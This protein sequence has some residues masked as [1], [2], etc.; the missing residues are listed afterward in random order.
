MSNWKTLE[1]DREELVKFINASVD[2][3]SYK[4]GAKLPLHIDY[5]DLVGKEID[6]SGYARV[7]MHAISHGKIIMPDGSFNQNS[8]CRSQG[9]KRTDYD[10]ASL[11]DDRLRIAFIRPPDKNRH[12]WY[13]INGQTIESCGGYGPHRRS[14]NSSVL[15]KNVDDCYVVTDPMNKKK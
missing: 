8:W 2:K 1:L 11:P 4:L 10:N 15:M 7:L 5:D 13:I 9:L 14:W 12:V 3:M 6:C